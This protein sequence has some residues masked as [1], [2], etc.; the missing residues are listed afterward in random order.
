VS[1]PEVIESQC[2]V[3]EFDARDRALV[4]R[5][6]GGKHRYLIGE[7]G[8]YAADDFADLRASVVALIDQPIALT[9]AA[10]R[11]EHEALGRRL[12]RFGTADDALDIWKSLG[13]AE[14]AR[15]PGLAKEPFLAAATPH[16]ERADA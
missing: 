14:P 8:S 1:G 2:G 11:A 4:W 12:E 7:A 9:I 16:R 10:V 3:E 6:M 15:V 5:T 13:V